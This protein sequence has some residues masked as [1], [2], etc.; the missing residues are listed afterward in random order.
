[1]NLA[2]INDLATT[3]NNI[4][5]SIQPKITE[6][7]SS[8]TSAITVKSHI[9]IG[10]GI[11]TFSSST[12]QTIPLPTYPAPDGTTAAQSDCKWFVG[13]IGNTGYSGTTWPCGRTDSP[14]DTSL[15]QTA[16]PTSTLTFAMYLQDHGGRIYT[17]NVA[18]IIIGT[19]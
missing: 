9:A 6:A 18:Y 12:P 13:L 17:T 5:N 8:T 11:L 15:V 3:Q 7:V 16:D 2:T 10:T 1:M 4:L 19:K 14:G